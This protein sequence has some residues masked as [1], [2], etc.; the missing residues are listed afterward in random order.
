MN[1][2]E[3]EQLLT[4]L[5]ERADFDA[6]GSAD[7]PSGVLRSAACL[8]MQR[9]SRLAGSDG[10]TTESERGHLAACRA[11]EGLL[12]AFRAER[13]PIRAGRAA[14][15]SIQS[16]LFGRVAPVAAMA[17]AACLL[18]WVGLRGPGGGGNGAIPL[19]SKSD[20]KWLLTEPM[21]SPGAGRQCIRCD[22]NCDGVI[23][24]A[25][26]DAFLLALNQPDKYATAH[27]NC[28]PV[29]VNDANCDGMLDAADVDPFLRCIAGG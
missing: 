6:P 24:S 4:L 12:A 26:L 17:A 18:L 16:V 9:L 10:G 15:R 29:C 13:L 3:L 23:T 21:A 22:A 1:D 11:C 28:D 19:P 14:R 2:R 25:D 5:H 20:S 7:R 27:P 8:P